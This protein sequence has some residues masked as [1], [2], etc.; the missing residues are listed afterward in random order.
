MAT[1]NEFMHGHVIGALVRSGTGTTHATANTTNPINHG[2]LDVTGAAITIT[3]YRV[4]AI[5]NNN[6]EG[7]VYLGATPI[8]TT[9]IDVLSPGTAVPYHW[10]IF[11]IDDIDNG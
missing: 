7:V 2:L 5:P 1:Y 11:H 9:Q 8:S 10:F 3:N 6:A 4:M